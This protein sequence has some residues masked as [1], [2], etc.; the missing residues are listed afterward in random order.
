MN[1]MTVFGVVSRSM[2]FVNNRYSQTRIPMAAGIEVQIIRVI[3]A[4]LCLPFS[5]SEGD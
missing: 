3:I 4:S 1:E 2:W 5:V